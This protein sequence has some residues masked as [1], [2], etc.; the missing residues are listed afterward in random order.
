MGQ[1]ST[2]AVL[3]R[4]IDYGDADLIL[5]LLTQDRGK[6][7]AIAKSAK[8]SVRR[9]GG[10]LDLFCILNVVCHSGRGNG[11]PVLQEAS[12]CQP[13]HRIRA[14][15]TRTAYASYWAELVC[16]WTESDTPQGEVFDLLQR[17]L[18]LL[19]EGGLSPPVLSVLFQ[20][21]FLGLAGMGPNLDCC[22]G[23]GRPLPEAVTGAPP[24]FDLGR[25]GVVCC[26]CRGAARRPLPLSL[27]TIKQLRWLAAGDLN[28]AQRIRF[29]PSALNEGETLL[30][31][32][33][34]YHLGKTLRSLDFLRQLRR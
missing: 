30:E 28:R 7:A 16:A 23:C 15:V 25:G 21:R 19:D 20:L 29:T 17:I 10:L 22:T 2:T 1:F 18:G 5:T 9:F 11:L 4:R 32:F 24:A 13:F 14:D 31:A 8:K 12:L 34:P 6:M 27:G 3:L 33:V 26:D